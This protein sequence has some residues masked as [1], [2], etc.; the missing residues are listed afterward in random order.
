LDS[1]VISAY[2]GLRYNWAMGGVRGN[3]WIPWKRYQW[4]A[5]TQNSFIWRTICGCIKY[6]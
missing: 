6:L 1:T 2:V 5:L 4:W 3:V